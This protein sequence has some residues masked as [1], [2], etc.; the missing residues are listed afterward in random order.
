MFYLSPLDDQLQSW[1]H[2]RDGLQF[3]GHDGFMV[4]L[5]QTKLASQGERGVV[6]GRNCV[7]GREGEGERGRERGE[8]ER[9]RE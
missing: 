7:E 3:G 4:L 2:L 9:G 8:G 5:S 1:V 6:R